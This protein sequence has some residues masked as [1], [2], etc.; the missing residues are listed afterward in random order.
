MFVTWACEQ[1]FTAEEKAGAALVM[2]NSMRMCV[3]RVVRLGVEPSVRVGVRAR[4]SGG[5]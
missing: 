3:T 1:G 4:G 2:G 5:G